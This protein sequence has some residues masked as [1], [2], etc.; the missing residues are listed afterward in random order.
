MIAAQQKESIR[1]SRD[2]LIAIGLPIVRRTAYRMARRLPPNVDVGDLIGAG[3][4]GLL[5]AIES[6]DFDRYERFEPYADARIRGAILD[7]LRASDSM[8]RHGRRRL[9][10]A[11][12]GRMGFGLGRDEGFKGH[13]QRLRGGHH[14]CSLRPCRGEGGPRDRGE[15]RFQQSRLRLRPRIPPGRPPE[16]RPSHAGIAWI[17]VQSGRGPGSPGHRP[18]TRGKGEKTHG[19]TGRSLFAGPRKSGVGWIAS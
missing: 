11:P 1:P 14:R 8:T 5:K 15:L 7:E 12:G 2:E 13:L 9:G 19:R 4:E 17:T 10:E 18:H 16:A 6:F 3:S